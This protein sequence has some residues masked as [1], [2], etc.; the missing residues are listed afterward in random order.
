MS[1]RYIPINFRCTHR[2]FPQTAR[3]VALLLAQR[4]TTG[5]VA[6]RAEEGEKLR[7]GATTMIGSSYST[8]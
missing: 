1:Q 5:M 3:P 7:T 6:E 8:G 2:V 4:K